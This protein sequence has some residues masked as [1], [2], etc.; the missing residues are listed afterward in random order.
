MQFLW[1]RNFIWA[2]VSTFR[3]LVSLQIS[4]MDEYFGGGKISDVHRL[5]SYQ[6]I[7]WIPASHISVT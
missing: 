6:K 5:S 7:L 2:E 4:F 3:Q 1:N